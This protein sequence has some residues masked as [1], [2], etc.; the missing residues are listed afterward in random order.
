MKIKHIAQVRIFRNKQSFKTF[1]SIEKILDKNKAKEY[2]EKGY[3]VLPN[4][5]NK[6]YIDELRNEI[7]NVLSEANQQEIRSIFDAGHALMDKYFLDS[8]DNVR[9]K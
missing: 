4:V 1:T 5:F 9:R 8:G 2:Q 6:N 7:D 3:A